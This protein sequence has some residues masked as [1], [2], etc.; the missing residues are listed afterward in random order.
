MSAVLLAGIDLAWQSEKNGTGVAIG[1]V[2]SGV[3]NVTHAESG[4]TSIST[5]TS[6]LGQYP[7][8]QGIAIDA[9]LII[10]NASGQRHCE[11]LIGK[12]YGARKASCHTSNLKLYPEAASVA[13]SRVLDEQGFTHL[14]SAGKWQVECYPHPALIEIFNLEERLLYKKGR[15]PVRR[16]GQAEL[17]RLLAS[18]SNSPV[19]PLKIPG[20]LSERLSQSYVQAL[21]GTALKNNEDLLDALVCLYV[22]G[23]YAI[24][25]RDRVFGS[26]AEGYIYVPY[27]QCT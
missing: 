18:L 23:L 17:G 2:E 15:V 27:R 14:G 22:A 26:V 25:H 12:E 10:N 19:L 20:H 1:A 16:D 21:A 11:K 3:L 4:V 5:I 7:D 9:P 24:G 13:L 6:L 8:L